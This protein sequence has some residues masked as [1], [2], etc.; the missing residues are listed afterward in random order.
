[1]FKILSYFH[2][3]NHSRYK[4][5]GDEIRDIFEQIR[6]GDVLLKGYN[7]IH[8]LFKHDKYPMGGIYISDGYVSYINRH[9][10]DLEDLITFCMCDRIMIIRLDSDLFIENILKCIRRCKQF[11]NI[12]KS[13]ECSFGG[14]DMVPYSLDLIDMCYKELKINRT[15]NKIRSEDILDHPRFNLIYGNEVVLI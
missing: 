7:G 8:N 9:G 10:A 5:K 14:I 12:S 15:N 3:N 4:I 2:K 6:P 11:I 13:Y 1:M